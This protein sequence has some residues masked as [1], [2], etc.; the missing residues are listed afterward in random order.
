MLLPVAPVLHV[1]V[2]V[3][4]VAVKVA[5]SL[6]QMLVLLAV[7]VGAGGVEPVVMVTTF[8]TPLVPQLFRQTAE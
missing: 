1:S 2:P 7:T 3:Q 6:P 5:V 8:D 4:P